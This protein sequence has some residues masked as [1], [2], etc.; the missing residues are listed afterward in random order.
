M[1]VWHPVKMHWTLSGEFRAEMVTSWG[2]QG[3][4]PLEARWAEGTTRC[5]QY[6]LFLQLHWVLTRA[7]L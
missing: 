6:F 5:T 2:G 1:W 4:V 3:P 7:C